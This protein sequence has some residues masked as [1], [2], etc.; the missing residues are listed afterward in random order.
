MTKLRC[1]VNAGLLTMALLLQ[2][3]ASV[4]VG[5]RQDVRVET[6]ARGEPVEDADCEL[7]NDK[8]RWVVVTPSVIEIQSSAGDLRV[9]CA[10]DTHEP[11]TATFQSSLGAPVFGNVLAGGIIGAVV[12]TSTGA[13]F[14]YPTQLP[15]LLGP[16][17]GKAKAVKPK[18]VP[19][20]DLAVGDVLEYTVTDGYSGKQRVVAWKVERVSDTQMAFDGERRVEDRRFGGV[21]RKGSATSDMEYY[22][23]ADGW[24]RGSVAVESG[25]SRS[26]EVDDGARPARLTWKAYVE[27]EEDIVVAGRKLRTARV[28]Y[29]GNGARYNGVVDVQSRL[30][31]TAWVEPTS[32]R[33]V[34]FE[35]L[36]QSSGGSQSGLASKERIELTR[37]VQAAAKTP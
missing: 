12:D 14:R 3:C 26:Y 27:N 15:V 32:R 13:A 19:L 35:S 30:S 11:G 1:G 21:T 8:G 10:I 2:G 9:N 16:S 7:T 28:E 22:E 17:T 5:N 33:I 34:R 24:L 4:T 37:V 23:P 31:F 36:V 25:W 6:A 18:V 20:I 29:R